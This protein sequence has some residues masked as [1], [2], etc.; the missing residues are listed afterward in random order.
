MPSGVRQIVVF[1]AVALVPLAAPSADDA[2]PGSRLHP[3][4]RPPH[5]LVVLIGG[6]DSDPT[7]RQIEGTARRQE[8]NS[9]LFQLAGDLRRDGVQ[10]EYFNWNGTRAGRIK[11][12][13]SPRAP[14]IAEFVDRH[15]QRNPGDRVAVIG[16][17]WGGHTALEVLQQ[18]TERETPL[19]VD[20]VVF[21]DPSSTGRGPPKPKSLPVNANHAISYCT[22]NA[23]VWG[24]WDAGGRLEYIDLGDPTLGFMHD[25]Q[26]AY[27]AK[28]NTAAHI[29]AEWDQQ[30]HQDILRR[31]LELLPK[32]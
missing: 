8:G 16:N 13:N 18:L 2:S 7:P 30:I 28:F 14:G 15:L 9:G 26:P 29:A 4:R 23:F 10:A 27:G 11:D 21:L 22:R 6:V 3:S 17:S 1:A 31:V 24:Q 32:P 19:A 20:L 12:K 25:G 5:L